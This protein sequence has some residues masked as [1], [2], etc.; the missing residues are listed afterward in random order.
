MDFL[1][2][3]SERFSV[4]DFSDRPVEKEKIDT[5]IESARIAPTAKNNQ[6]QIVYVLKSEEALKKIRENTRCAFNAPLVFAICIDESKQW[7]QPFSGEFSGNIDGAIVATHMMLMAH[8]LGVGCTW[9]MH[10]DPQKMRKAY[11]IPENVVPHALL[12]MGYAADDSKPLDMHFE[13]KDAE[14]ISVYDSF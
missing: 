3:A 6:P 4:R 2:L 9:V 8:S 11:N 14:E 10:F 5:I 7:R 1:K 12:T 13:K